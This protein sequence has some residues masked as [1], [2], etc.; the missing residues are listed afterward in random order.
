MENR[1]ASLSAVHLKCHSQNNSKHHGR[2]EYSDGRAIESLFDAFA[3]S[4]LHALQHALCFAPM[5]EKRAVEL[6]LVVD[7]ANKNLPFHQRP[8]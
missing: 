7:V 2:I 1:M 5:F 4:R 6:N 3:I 8:D